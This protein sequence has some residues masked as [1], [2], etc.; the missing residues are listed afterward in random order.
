MLSPVYLISQ[1][2]GQE[3]TNGQNSCQGA[4]VGLVAQFLETHYTKSEACWPYNIMNTNPRA[5]PRDLTSLGQNACYDC[6]TN[7]AGSQRY[8][9]QS[10]S[11]K[12]LFALTQNGSIDEKNTVLA[13]KK[14]IMARGPVVTAFDVYSDF[15]PYWDSLRSNPKRVYQR[16]RNQQLQGGHAVVITGWGRTTDG[17]SF[18]EIRNSW[19]N[20]GDSGYGYIRSDIEMSPDLRIGVDIPVSMGR[21]NLRGGVTTFNPAGSAGG[22]YGA[23]NSKD[24]AS[25]G[26]FGLSITMTFIIILVIIALLITAVLLLK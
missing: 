15:K 22:A 9:I 26:L 3:A 18:W 4:N 1:L 11:S 10:G 8:S 5:A 12:P 24:D 21:G 17:S 7:P 19:G 16:G 25:G 13:I 2:N 6:N 23:D 14:E 20:T